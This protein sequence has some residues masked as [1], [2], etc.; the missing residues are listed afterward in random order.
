MVSGLP[1]LF[2][3]ADKALA[4]RF[5]HRTS[6][7]T[8]MQ[9]SSSVWRQGQTLW[10]ADGRYEDPILL[11]WDWALISPGALVLADP[12]SVASNVYPVD[13]SGHVSVQTRLSV[14]MQLVTELDW[15][16]TVREHVG[17]I[18]DS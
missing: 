7:I 16:E 3:A 4:L 15:S 12:M 13:A 10:Q 5:R 14:L 1:P 17:V 9:P 8:T 11:A 2:I 18:I 6:T